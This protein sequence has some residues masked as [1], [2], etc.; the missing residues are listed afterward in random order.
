MALTSQTASQI[1]ALSLTQVLITPYCLPQ[2]PFDHCVICLATAS[3]AF[4]WPGQTTSPSHRCLLEM[5]ILGPHLSP[6]E[7]ELQVLKHE[8]VSESPGE[9]VTTQIT[10]GFTPISPLSLD[11]TK[12]QLLIQEV[13]N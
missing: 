8:H 5:Q 10:Q 12:P 1:V 4:H 7:C 13:W 6:T 9:L 11:S 2:V 3:Y